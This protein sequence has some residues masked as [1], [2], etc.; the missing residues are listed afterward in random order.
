MGRCSPCRVSAQSGLIAHRWCSV[1]AEGPGQ[2]AWHGRAAVVIVQGRG[3][4]T[5]WAMPGCMWP[6]DHRLD[7]LSYGLDSR[8]KYKSWFSLQFSVVQ[9]WLGG[10]WEVKPP[11]NSTIWHGERAVERLECWQSVRLMKPLTC[12][13]CVRPLISNTFP[14]CFCGQVHWIPAPEE[15]TIALLLL[16]VI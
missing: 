5:L 15:A 2:A 3:W 7:M 13:F 8:C 4:A 9:E 10:G 16:Y 6:M 12:V 11:C 14:L 1:D